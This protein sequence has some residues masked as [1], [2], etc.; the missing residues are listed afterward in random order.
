MQ[1]SITDQLNSWWMIFYINA[2]FKLACYTLLCHYATWSSPAVSW[3]Q[4]SCCFGLSPSGIA[5]KLNR[6]QLYAVYGSGQRGGV[7]D[8]LPRRCLLLGHLS[9]AKV[10]L[11]QLYKYHHQSGKADASDFLV[12]TFKHT[13]IQ[14]ITIVEHR[15]QN[16][17]S[18]MCVTLQI[19]Y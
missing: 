11:A 8:L 1:S 12:L 10:V 17:L 15:I 4:S 5:P 7:I 13:E 16:L 19:R 2:G 3:L 9:A 14:A 18:P 6:V